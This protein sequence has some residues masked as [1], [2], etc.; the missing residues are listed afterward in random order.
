MRLS[1]G[2][3]LHGMQRFVR[4]NMLCTY[5]LLRLSCKYEC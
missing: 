1:A 3:M 4:Q 2:V 5:G